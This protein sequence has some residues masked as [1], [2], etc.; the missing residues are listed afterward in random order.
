MTVA[1]LTGNY[2]AGKSTVARMFSDLG[3]LTLDTDRIT[4]ELLME[5]DVIRQIEFL[6]DGTVS[7][8]VVN[9]KILADRVFGDARLRLMLEDIIHPLVFS[10]IGDEISRIGPGSGGVV[11]VEAPVI[12]ERGHQTRFDRIITVYVTEEINMQRLRAKG[13]QEEEISRRLASQLPAEI[14]MRGS[15]FIIDNSR[16][17]ENTREQVR[18]VYQ[19]LLSNEKK[20][21]NN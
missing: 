18:A 1:G 9:K 3:A 15:D 21:G 20:H 17:L 2:G 8:G 12:F 6:F 19:D 13:I 16:D 14:K 7:D 5:P 10:R 11:I 4:A